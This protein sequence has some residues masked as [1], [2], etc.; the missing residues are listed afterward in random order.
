MIAEGQVYPESVSYNKLPW[1]YTA[2][3]P[4]ILGNIVSAQA[5]RL[6]L[7]FALES[8]RW[9]Y[10]RSDGKID[11]IAVKLAMGK[12]NSYLQWLTKE[13]IGRM[14]DIPGIEIYGPAEVE[15]RAP[16]ISFNIN[17]INPMTLANKLAERGVEVRAGC[18]CASLAHRYLELDPLGSCRLSFYIYNNIEDV[19]KAVDSVK[20]IALT[21]GHR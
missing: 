14:S 8:D 6:I 12:V 11:Q 1:K 2:G 18:H 3:T 16:L 9:I 21:S 20:H 7:D 19:E 17:G 15:K 4:N 5:L 10:F 13:T